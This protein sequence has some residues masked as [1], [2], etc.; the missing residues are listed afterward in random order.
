MSEFIIN[1]EKF[2]FGILDQAPVADKNQCILLYRD[3]DGENGSYLIDNYKKVYTSDIRRGKYNIKVVFS[4]SKKTSH[5]S[6]NV[7]MK[8]NGYY[9]KVN[10]KMSYTLKNIRNYYFKDGTDSIQLVIKEVRSLLNKHDG[11]WEMQQGNELE[12]ELV[13]GVEDILYRN[14][15][16]KF[17][18]IVTEVQPDENAK[19]IIRS[20]I[21]KDFVMREQKNDAI[22]KVDKNEKQREILQ[23]EYHVHEVKAQQLQKAA[24]AF[25]R[26]A[27]IAMEY[28]SGNMSGKE[29][30]QYIEKKQER[31]LSILLET[32]RE[33]LL[34]DQIFQ[35]DLNKAIGNVDFMNTGAQTR[36]QNN[37]SGQI[38]EK[39]EEVVDVKDGDFL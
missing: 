22:V 30:Y 15:S 31:D 21:D 13:Q 18:D 38:E 26:L 32:R 24:E 19:K 29:L 33:D 20:D 23:S 37:L 17:F 7:A 36:L 2:R 3:K 14:I 34:T 1:K 6:F 5:Y 11:Y 4:L 27:P 8:N 9:F 10:L 25:G 12:K 28:L 16:L 39:T 35:N